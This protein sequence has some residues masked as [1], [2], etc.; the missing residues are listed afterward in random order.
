MSAYRTWRWS[1]LPASRSNAAP[2]WPALVTNLARWASADLDTPVR[3]RPDAPVFAGTEPVT[4]S[5]RVFDGRGELVSD[6][7]V[8][9]TIANEEGEELPYSMTHAGGGQYRADAGA[10]PA[11]SYTYTATAARGGTDLGTDAGSFDV[12]TPNVE[13]QATR[14]NLELLTQLA[15]RTGGEV[16]FLEEAEVLPER[17][18]AHPDFTSIRRAERSSQTL[19]HAWPFLVLLISLLSAE[20]FLRKRQGLA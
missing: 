9:L 7:A 12:D 15:A 10:L 6:A 11:G 20:W 19:A 3:V 13:R 5:G 17:L 18:Q 1:T 16:L 14:A 4:F 8:S 2:L